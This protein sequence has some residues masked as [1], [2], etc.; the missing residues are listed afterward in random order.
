MRIF[1]GDSRGELALI[2]TITSMI[3]LTNTKGSVFATKDRLHPIKTSNWRRNKVCDGLIYECS[4][5]CPHG[6]S[7]H[8]LW[9][10]SHRIILCSSPL[11]RNI[12]YTNARIAAGSPY[13]SSPPS[14]QKADHNKE[15]NH[16]RNNFPFKC[17][18]SKAWV[19][20]GGWVGRFL[21]HNVGSWFRWIQRM[22]CRVQ[23]TRGVSW[24]SSA[25]RR[26]YSRLR[27]VHRTCQGRAYA[28]RSASSERSIRMQEPCEPATTITPER[29][30]SSWRRRCAACSTSHETTMLCGLK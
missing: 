10:V 5:S 12:S 4:S 3:Y 23:S 25:W 22:G 27:A 30:E 28:D 24:N 11:E 9:F 26:H 13:S 1:V 8:R 29:Q 15:E 18:W 20:H 14:L 21:F 7:D 17:C 6:L 19:I 16:G 2:I